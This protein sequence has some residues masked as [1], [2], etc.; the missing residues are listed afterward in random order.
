MYFDGRADRAVRA[1]WQTLTDA[2]LPSLA[3]LTHRRHRPH[4]TLAVAES[5]AAVDAVRLRAALTARPPD[6]RLYVLGTFPGNEGALFLG[7]QVTGDLLAYHSGVH[8]ALA[9][10]PVR[11][12]PY[13]QPGN[14]VPHCTLAEGL[15]A[16]QA[17]RAFALLRGYQP[18]TAAVA[19]VGIKD[20]ATGEVTGLTGS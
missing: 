2:G 3:T 6:L 11:P 18:I 19:A 9:G 16:G 1:L 10:A 5:L 14:W 20:T 7:L 17:G 13:Y 12:W 4:A 15:D 8:A